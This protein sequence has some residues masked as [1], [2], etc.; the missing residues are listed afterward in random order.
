MDQFFSRAYQLFHR[1]LT[2]FVGNVSAVLLLIG[3]F[4]AIIEIFRRYIFGVVFEWGQDAVIFFIAAAMFLYFPV[5]QAARAHLVMSAMIDLFKAKRMTGLVRVTRLAGSIF[6]CV[7]CA[8]IAYWSAPTILRSFQIE[9]K[10]LSMAFDVWPFQLC[11]A[12]GF[13]L[14]ALV[15]LFQVYQDLRTLQGKDVF[16]WAASEE[17]TDL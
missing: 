11:L 2:E 7:L 10:T 1:F 6:T 9:R 8:S 3:T 13:G 14:M 12:I 5:A 16:R 15:A 17:T 4:F